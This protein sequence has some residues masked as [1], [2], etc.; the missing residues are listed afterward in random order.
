M[1]RNVINTVQKEEATTPFNAGSV[2]PRSTASSMSTKPYLQDLDTP[3][4]RLFRHP[5][6]LLARFDFDRMPSS[7]EGG[8]KYELRYRYRVPKAQTPCRDELIYAPAI[9]RRDSVRLNDQSNRI[10]DTLLDRVT[11]N[12]SQTSSPKK[13]RKMTPS[14]TNKTVSMSNSQ[15]V[16]KNELGVCA[17]W[18]VYPSIPIGTDLRYRYAARYCYWRTLCFPHCRGRVGRTARTV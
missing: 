15:H 14:G 13:R 6:F 11:W 7:E 2:D 10:L 4:P 12:Y 8:C 3:S 16:C 1:V 9:R 17:T 5:T 18:R